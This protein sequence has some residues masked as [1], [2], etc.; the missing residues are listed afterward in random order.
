MTKSPLL[1]HFTHI[2]NLEGIAR[3]GGLHCKNNAEPQKNASYHHIQSRRKI[4]QIECGP[5]GFIHD[6]VPFYFAPRSP[7][8]SAIFNGKIPNMKQEDMVYLISNT[9]KMIENQLQFVFTDGHSTMAIT[10]FFDDTKD[11]DKVDWEIM[12]AER[13]AI[14]LDDP[15]RTRRRQA[16]FMVYNFFPLEALVGVAVF[17]ESQKNTVEETLRKNKINLKHILIKRHFYF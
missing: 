15:D 13:W 17:D 3:A 12:R 11:L 16:E 9:E 8:L 5:Q 14:T 6:Y 2:Q 1:Y 7:M 10:R 4:R